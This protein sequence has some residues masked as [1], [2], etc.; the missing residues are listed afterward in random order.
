MT[1]D[2][3]I[4]PAPFL[5]FK[6]MLRANHD[7]QKLR[8]LLTEVAVFC[9]LA[10]SANAQNDTSVK[11][12]ELFPRATASC[13]EWT[14]LFNAG[15]APVNVRGWYV[16]RPGDSS[17]ITAGDAMI[18]GGGF[19]VMTKDTVQFYAAFPAVRHAVQPQHWHSLDNYHDTL[20]LWDA[21][22]VP[23][24]SVGWDYRWFTAWENQSLSRVSFRVS[25]FDRTAWVLAENPTPGQ[26]NPEVVWRSA[27]AASLEIGPIPFTPNNDGRD[28][29]L[30]IKLMLPPG[31]TGSIAVYGFDGRKYY[32]VATV[33][34]PEILW[35][36]KTGSGATVPCGPFFVI[37]EVNNG[38]S[39]I[40]IR[41]KGVLWGGFCFYYFFALF[42]FR[43]RAAS[44]FPSATAWRQTGPFFSLT[45]FPAGNRLQARAF[46]TIRSTTA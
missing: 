35:N 1:S 27:T 17:L 24:D 2:K 46:T 37:A 3:F 39:K 6:I 26:P 23:R 12:N 11:I 33:V 34:S 4:V 43:A 18:P 32:D 30:S 5:Y 16:G 44:R 10:F 45:G 29:Y 22:G 8:I 25:G 42:P 14:E 13:P 28:D 21:N 41:K 36:G 40:V 19:L 15:S 9:L 31:A 20:M 38:G 7:K